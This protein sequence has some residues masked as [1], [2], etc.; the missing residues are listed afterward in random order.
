MGG[1]VRVVII[2]VIVLVMREMGRRVGW[3]RLSLRTPMGKSA[4]DH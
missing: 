4:D 3:V 2:G 1:E